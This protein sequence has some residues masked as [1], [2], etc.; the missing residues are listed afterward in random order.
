MKTVNYIVFIK[1]H[2]LC[3]QCFKHSANSVAMRNAT[4]STVLS[5]QE[6]FCKPIWCKFHGASE[7]LYN[8]IPFTKCF[9]IKNFQ[10]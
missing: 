7:V 4:L 3:K 8:P 1:I 10:S 5:P 9:G 2:L 6:V